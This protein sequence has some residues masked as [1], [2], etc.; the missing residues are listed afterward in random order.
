MGIHQV[1]PIREDASR[2]QWIKSSRVEYLIR[3]VLQMVHETKGRYS[4]MS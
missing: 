3:E 1:A 4:V 2:S